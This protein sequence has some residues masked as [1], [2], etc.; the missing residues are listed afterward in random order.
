MSWTMLEACR[1]S[2]AHVEIF[3]DANEGAAKIANIQRLLGSAADSSPPATRAGDADMLDYALAFD[4]PSLALLLSHD[5]AEREY[6]YEGVATTF[7]LPS[8]SP[9]RRRAV[10]GRW[11]PWR[12]T[13]PRSSPPG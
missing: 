3:G 10:A 9:P 13:G 5:D 1:G 11:C 8:P 7:R 2:C 6:V 4:G 12:T